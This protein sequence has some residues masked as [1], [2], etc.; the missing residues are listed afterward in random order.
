MVYILYMCVYTYRFSGSLDNDNND[1]GEQP[2]ADSL[3][4]KSVTSVTS[5]PTPKKY[6]EYSKGYSAVFV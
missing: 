2:G 5:K 6:G 3:N 4:S 1:E